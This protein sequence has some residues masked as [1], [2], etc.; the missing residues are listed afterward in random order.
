MNPRII[1]P[2]LLRNAW[3][4]S[5]VSEDSKKALSRA[6]SSKRIASFGP[7]EEVIGGEIGNAYLSA[8]FFRYGKRRSLEMNIPVNF[9]FWASVMA[10][11]VQV[12]EQSVDGRFA[13]IRKKRF[14]SDY[15][16]K[17]FFWFNAVFLL[18]YTAGI[19]LYEVLGGSW[20]IFPLSFAWI[21]VIN[22]FK[23]AIAT[24][25]LREYSPGL[26]A[27]PIHWIL[28][29]FIMRYDLVQ[30]TII[31]SHFV[32]SAIIGAGIVVLMVGSFLL[33]SF[34]VGSRPSKTKAA[35]TD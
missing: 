24:G 14:W 3:E 12:A 31:K 16:G 33:K 20:I 19:L 27:S 11:C 21:L 30:G 7:G 4:S 26:I 34:L 8:S 17:T 29:Y 13:N 32:V 15:G 10:L 6:V 18:V 23:H 28:M 5:L 9:L 1:P 22:G 25:I 35:E 2:T